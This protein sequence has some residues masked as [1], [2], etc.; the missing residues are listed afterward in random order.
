LNPPGGL[1]TIDLADFA[2][3]ADIEAVTN[4]Y[5]EIPEVADQVV[6]CAAIIAPIMITGDLPCNPADVPPRVLRNLEKDAKFNMLSGG[7][8][9][10]FT[11][12]LPK[13]SK[14]LSGRSLNIQLDSTTK[15]GSCAFGLAERLGLLP[16]RTNNVLNEV[17]TIPLDDLVHNGDTYCIQI[18]RHF[19]V[20]LISEHVQEVWQVGN[21]TYA[22]TDI[23]RFT[24][25]EH[26]GRPFVHYDGSIRTTTA[27]TIPHQALE[28]IQQ[29]ANGMYRSTDGAL[30]PYSPS[31]AVLSI[32]PFPHVVHY[33]RHQDI[34][35][36]RSL[37]DFAEVL[38]DVTQ[39]IIRTARSPESFTV[40]FSKNW[41]ASGLPT[42]ASEAEG[43][44]AS[45]QLGNYLFGRRIIDLSARDIGNQAAQFVIKDAAR[46]H[47]VFRGAE[48][49]INTFILRSHDRFQELFNSH[50]PGIGSG[51]LRQQL[52]A[53]LSDPRR[54]NIAL[55]AAQ[56]G[57]ALLVRCNSQAILNLVKD[58]PDEWMR[59]VTAEDGDMFL[60]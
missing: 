10:G 11:V 25:Y 29:V 51:F 56:L 17:E 55:V 41:L 23:G 47:A 27:T 5:L 45:I 42:N 3:G 18:S 43:L 19:L 1:D 32:E 44:A 24:L 13:F 39:S 57:L 8:T 50:Q 2:R 7:A 22:S 37:H 20:W 58:S 14:A 9:A 48:I 52:L 4:Q 35:K 16:D 54:E 59:V 6:N 30:A 40:A 33:M 49:D 28:D 38:G 60:G 26:E 15:F 21:R 34:E 12:T 46:A 53:L 31:I 36:F